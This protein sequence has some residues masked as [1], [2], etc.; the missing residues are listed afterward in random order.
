MNKHPNFPHQDQILSSKEL[1]QL[2]GLKRRFWESRRIKG[3]SPPFIRISDKCIRYRWGDVL[4]WFEQRMRK[5]T[6]DQGVE[7]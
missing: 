1:E 2:T 6:S 7:Q 4:Q 5:S 3:D